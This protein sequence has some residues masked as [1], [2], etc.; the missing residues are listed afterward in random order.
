MALLRREEADNDRVASSATSL[1]AGIAQVVRA[2]P[3]GIKVIKEFHI[4]SFQF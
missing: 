4:A 3:K 2:I 1:V